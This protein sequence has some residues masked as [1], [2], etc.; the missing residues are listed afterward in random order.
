MRDRRREERDFARV[1]RLI[2]QPCVSRRAFL[3]TA[4]ATA[5][6]VAVTPSIAHASPKSLAASPPDGFVPMSAPGRVVKI[7][8]KDTMQ[9]NKLYPKEDAAKEMVTRALTELTGKRDLTSSLAQFVHKNDIVC[10]K[11]NG[12]ARTQFATN[13]EV[14]LPVVGALVELGVKPENITLLE[15]YYGF[16]NATRITP[17]NAPAGVKIAN[18]ANKDSTMDERLIPGTGVKTKFAR[19]LT[20]STCVLNFGLVKDHSQTGYTG[21]MKNM[22]H[23]TS[24]NPQDFHVHHGSPQI[25]LMYAQDVI[26]SRVRLCVYDAFKVMPEGGPLYKHP[27]FV[28]IHEA[29]YASTDPVALDTIGWEVVEDYRSKLNVKTLAEAGREPGYIKAAADLGLGIHDRKQIQLKEVV[30]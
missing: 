8:K 7:L 19:V 25:A 24:M 4:A 1:E 18:H 11:V 17:Q 14:V 20:E 15:Q 30:L 28:Q 6:A 21:A 12:I 23:G 26:R 27:E 2:S 22:T 3:G 10:V 9:V 16:F 13:K 29:I 5:A